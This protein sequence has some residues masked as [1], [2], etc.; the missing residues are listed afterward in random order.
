MRPGGGVLFRSTVRPA[1]VL[2]R[3]GL[4]WLAE[5]HHGIRTGGLVPLEELGL[6]AP[7]RVHYKPAPWRALPR[8]QVGPDD[9]FVDLGSGMG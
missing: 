6:A 9:V 8:R 5:R 1:Y 3:D 7:D 4:T 2:A